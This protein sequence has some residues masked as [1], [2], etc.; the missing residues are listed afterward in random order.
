MKVSEKALNSVPH[1]EK[2]ERGREKKGRKGKKGERV[3]EISS[4]R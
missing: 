3:R 2:D 1:P 4:E